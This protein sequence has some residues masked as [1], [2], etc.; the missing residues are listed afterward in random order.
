[1]V[2]V[3]CQRSQ[4]S[5]KSIKFMQ[6]MFLCEMVGCSWGCDNQERNIDRP[7]VEIKDRINIRQGAYYDSW[8]MLSMCIS[9]SLDKI[10]FVMSRWPKTGCCGSKHC[11]GSAHRL[12]PDA[13]VSY[14]TSSWA[15]SLIFRT[16]ALLR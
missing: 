2:L 10:Y 14:L 9:G 13:G 6:S 7:P 1:M 4:H 11:T 3:L 8:Q 15:F 5:E 12:R 16:R